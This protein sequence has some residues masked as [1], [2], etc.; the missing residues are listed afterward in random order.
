MTSRVSLAPR[1]SSMALLAT[2]H[3]YLIAHTYSC[4]HDHHPLVTSCVCLS[5]ASQLLNQPSRVFSDVIPKSMALTGGYLAPWGAL[6]VSRDL[7]FCH[8]LK[9]GRAIVIECIEVRTLQ[10]IPESTGRTATTLKDYN[11]DETL[12]V[13]AW[14]SSRRP[15][16][17]LVH[18]VG[19]QGQ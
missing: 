14:L 10:N 5:G 15:G 1:S 9:R 6:V 4:T 17:D 12:R 7:F 19:S 3:T 13:C 18:P 2:E 16:Y 11:E 8:N